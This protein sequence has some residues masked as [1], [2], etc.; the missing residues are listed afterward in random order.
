MSAPLSHR[1]GIDDSRPCGCPQ[2]CDC[3]GPN[4]AA[5]RIKAAMRKAHDAKAEGGAA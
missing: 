3:D 1:E 5:D 4:A 2:D